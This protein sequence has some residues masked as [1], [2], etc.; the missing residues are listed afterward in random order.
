MRNRGLTEHVRNA[1]RVLLVDP[2]G[3]VLLLRGK[4]PASPGSGH[5]WITPG[6]GVAE[7]ETERDA[8][9]RECWEELGRRIDTF[10]GP[11]DVEISEFAFDGRWLVQRNVYFVARV[12]RFI[13]RPADLTSTERRVLLGWRWWSPADIHATGETLY[14]EN[15]PT[16]VDHITA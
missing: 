3:H 5:W 7:G 14:P 10:E 6:G 9:A 16:L 15:L 12:P 8:A 1:A 13:P 11:I 2:D 4:D